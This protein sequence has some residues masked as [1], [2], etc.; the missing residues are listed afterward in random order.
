MWR[1]VVCLKYGQVKSIPVKGMLA[2]H[3]NIVFYVLEILM[4]YVWLALKFLSVTS[5]CMSEKYGQ[6]GSI[7]SSIF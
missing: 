6:V 4:V 2:L 1:A 3:F 7:T 5:G